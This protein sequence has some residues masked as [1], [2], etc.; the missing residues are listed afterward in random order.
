M[1]PELA[2]IMQTSADFR[3]DTIFRLAEL[4]AFLRDRMIPIVP[5]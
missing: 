4:Q 2:S 1:E 3:K 5:Q